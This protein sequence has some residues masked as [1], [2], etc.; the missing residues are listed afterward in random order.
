MAHSGG[1]DARMPTGIEGLDFLLDGGLPANRLY[2]I[3]GS[4]STG[5]TTLALQ[6]LL[7]GRR[8][9]ET[10]LYVT[11]SET[12]TE[13][14]GVAASHGWLLEGLEVFEVARPEMRSPEDQY[15]LYHPSEIE[16]GEMVTSVMEI[17]DRIRPTRVVLDSLSEVRLLAQ[18]PLRYRRQIMALKE[19]FP[20]DRRGG[21]AAGSRMDVPEGRR[22]EGARCGCGFAPPVLRYRYGIQGV[23]LG[24]GGT[25]GRGGRGGDRPRGGD[26]ARAIARR[27][28]QG[29]TDQGVCA[30]P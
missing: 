11:L 23:V 13:L 29:R 17:A 10:C 7:E 21:R 12:A 16:L 19:Y 5:K 2:L 14:Q 20:G 9:A 3:E 8:H 18:D 25:D 1:P 4:Q 6:F 30:V 15:T 28:R 22:G 27:P 24:A 26:R